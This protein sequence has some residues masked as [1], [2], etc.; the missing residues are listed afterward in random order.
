LF[1]KYLKRTDDTSAVSAKAN[2]ALDE[3][4]QS[5][6]LRIFNGKIEKNK[7]VEFIPF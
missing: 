7:E 2:T 3:S 6:T 1:I 4:K 5:L